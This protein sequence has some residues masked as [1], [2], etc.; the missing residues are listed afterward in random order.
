MK[1]PA[2]SPKI[3]DTSGIR[4]LV[5][6]LGDQLSCELET[7]RSFDPKQDAVWMAESVIEAEYVWSHKQ[8]IALFLSAMRHFRKELESRGIRVFYTEL[9][10]NQDPK[11][12]DELLEHFLKSKNVTGSV[13][14]TEPGEWRLKKAFKDLATNITTPLKM[15]EDSSFL[16]SRDDFE[17][18]AEGRKQLRMEYFYREMR[19]RTGILMDGECPAGGEWNYDSSNRA[20]FG[21]RGPETV[22]PPVRFRSDSITREVIELVEHRFADHPGRLDTFA[23]PVASQDAKCALEDFLKKGLA[24]FGK[25]QDAMWTGEPF[26]NHSLLSPSL[27]LK[28]LS[29]REVIEA[30]EKEYREGRAPIE[31]VEGFIRQVIG[32]REY[33]RGVYW[34]Y[35][36]DYADRNA[37]GASE[38]LP[39]FYWTGQTSLNCLRQA[40]DQT[41]EYGYAHHIQRLMVT[42]LFALLWGVDPKE[43]HRWYLSIYVDAVEWVELPNTLGMSQYADGGVMA[44]KPYVSTGKYINR[45][46]NYCKGCRFRPDVRTGEDAC[47]ITVLY[48]DYLDRH[49]KALAGNQRMGLQLRNLK[50]MGA[51][52]RSGLRA[53]AQKTRQ[54]ILKESNN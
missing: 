53:R 40:L 27:N 47:P 1:K 50:R 23:W 49:E 52:E 48:W 18:W 39:D 3:S 42:G 29:P 44:S 8:R 38:A 37:M 32:W 12:L 46:S 54:W 41:L 20:S 2:R 30:V 16:C 11:G 22:P 26:L 35:M 31:S 45:M 43:V 15:L 4:N 5:V 7:F 21:K 24:D 13:L 33:V 19:K 17:N 51:E 34:R 10:K 9:E 25:Y 6:V 36:P 14:M 28:L